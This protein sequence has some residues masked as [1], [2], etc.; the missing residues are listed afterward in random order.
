MGELRKLPNKVGP[1]TFFNKEIAGAPP[2][3]TFITSVPVPQELHNLY[4]TI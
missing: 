3:E 4:H 2:E 1:E